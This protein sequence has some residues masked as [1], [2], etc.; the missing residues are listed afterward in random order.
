MKLAGQNLYDEVFRHFVTKMHGGFLLVSEDHPFIKLF[1]SCFK[2]LNIK[3]DNVHQTVEIGKVAKQAA[4]LTR[5]YKHLVV[6]LESHLQ[7]KSAIH[8]FRQLKELHPSR[9][10]VVCTTSEVSRDKIVHMQEMGA[11]NVIVKPVTMN[12][13]I[14]KIALTVRPNTKISKLVDTCKKLIGENKPFEAMQVVDIIFQEKPDSTIGFMLKGDIYRKRGE[15]KKAENAYMQASHQSRLYLEPLKRLTSLYQDLGDQ[16]KRLDYLKRLDHLSPLNHDR[17]V[18]IGAAC[19]EMNQEEEAKTFFAEA[20]KLVKKQNDDLM[21]ST[22]MEI[23]KKLQDKDP[24]ASLS[25]MAQAISLK[26]E[27]LGKDDIWMFNEI[28]L[29]YRKNGQAEKAIEYYQKAL[30]VAKDDG[31]IFYNIGMAHAE[32]NSLTLALLNFERAIEKTPDILNYSPQIPYNI[33]NIYQKAGKP[34]EA[35]HYFKICL[36]VDSNF[37]DARAKVEAL[38]GN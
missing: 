31:A 6:I 28:G 2:Y 14:Q 7:G 11:D 4:E 9:C 19:L 23:G 32:S 33:A 30:K 12:N 20:V 1:K 21:S 13:V 24:E 16:D 17:K 25:Y 29:N 3:T 27:H 15:F 36:V 10:N 8:L 35:S 5:R 18:E 37:K 22:L 34:R 38:D 26:E